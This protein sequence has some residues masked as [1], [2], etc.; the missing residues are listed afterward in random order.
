MTP[1]EYIQLKAFARQDGALMALLW[2]GSFGCYIAGLGHPIYGMIAVML[3][4]ATPFFAARRLRH[5]RDFGLEGIISMRR[6]W[7]FVVLIFFYASLL[8]AIAQYAYFAFLDHGFLM[9]TIEKML[10]SPETEQ[11]LKQAGMKESIEENLAQLQA[12]R[13][14]DI[15]LNVLTTNILIGMVLGLPIAASM[16]RIEKLKNY[17][18][19]I[20]KAPHGAFCIVS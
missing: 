8:L 1:A 17:R 11:M 7:A 5:F 14:I 9:D 10:H 3:A 2:I 12:M 6:G 16:R 19:K 15:A 18:I 13:P 20:L 4:V